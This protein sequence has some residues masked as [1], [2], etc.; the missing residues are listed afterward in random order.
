MENIK[1]IILDLLKQDLN[2]EIDRLKTHESEDFI[3][4]YD[5]EYYHNGAGWALCCAPDPVYN[6][7]ELKEAAK[8]K[9]IDYL[10]DSD[11][12]EFCVRLMESEKFINCLV[13]LINT[14]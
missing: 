6:K 10:K 7:E 14:L 12:S 3:I 1:N 11:D 5:K 8:D 13:D 9:I 4:G 2:Q